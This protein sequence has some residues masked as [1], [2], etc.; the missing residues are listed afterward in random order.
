MEGVKGESQVEGCVQGEDMT[1]V[2]SHGG[3]RVI[4]EYFGGRRRRIARFPASG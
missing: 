3:V 4:A 1:Q 2:G